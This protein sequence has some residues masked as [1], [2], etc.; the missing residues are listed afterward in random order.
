M[1]FLNNICFIST[2]TILSPF[3]FATEY[4]M[5]NNI[6]KNGMNISPAYLLGVTMDGHPK[7]MSTDPSAIHIELDIHA[8]KNN[9]HGYPENAWIPYLN[10]K[11][12]MEKLG[13]NYKELKTLANMQAIDGPHYA[14]NFSMAGPG[15]YKA[16][17][18]IEPPSVNGFIRHTDKDT[19]VPIWWQPFSVSWTFTY[20]SKE[21]K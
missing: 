13:S 2:L 7:G 3:V 18:T 4:Y 14:N 21:I 10:I 19:G 6:E 16:T 1:K 8:S 12:K 15:Q 17:Y 20:P 5:G 11:L 9:K